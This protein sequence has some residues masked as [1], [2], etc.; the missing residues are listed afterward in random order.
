MRVPRKLSTAL[1]TQ[2][3]QVQILPPLPNSRS[4]RC[5]FSGG[6]RSFPVRRMAPDQDRFWPY[7]GEGDLRGEN[8]EVPARVG[9]A[10]AQVRHEE[11]VSVVVRKATSRTSQVAARGPTV[12]R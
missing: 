12:H 10:N 9:V 11:L 5:T 3:S 8:P 1:I 2:R 6:P 7:S 4:A